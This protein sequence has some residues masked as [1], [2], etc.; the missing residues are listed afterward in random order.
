MKPQD[1]IFFVSLVILC[2]IRRS[3]WQT[4][5]GIACLLLAIPLYAKWVFFTAERLVW[6]ASAFFLVATVTEMGKERHIL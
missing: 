2:I 6:Y 4:I 5:A 3:K 1:L